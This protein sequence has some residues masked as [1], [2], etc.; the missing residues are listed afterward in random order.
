V[1]VCV[2]VQTV[3]LL[4]IQGCRRTMQVWSNE[5][6]VKE[7]RDFLD[8]KRQDDTNDGLACTTIQEH[9][10]NLASLLSTA[11]ILIAPDR[12]ERHHRRRTPRD[13]AEGR[14]WGF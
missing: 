2:S 7:Y 12:S 8:G 5:Q 9:Q 13:D 1:Y 11:L 4:R 6:A 10:V 14:R 3:L